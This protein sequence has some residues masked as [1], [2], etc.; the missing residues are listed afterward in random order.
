MLGIAGGPAAPIT[1]PMISLAGGI[2]GSFFGDYLGRY[3]VDM[4]FTKQTFTWI[5]AQ[6][7]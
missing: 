3:V 2:S 5:M 1:I 6:M 7:H 4:V